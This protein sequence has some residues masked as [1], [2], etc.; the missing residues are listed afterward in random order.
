MSL[1]TTNYYILHPTFLLYKNYLDFK[2]VIEDT[3]KISH[4]MHSSMPHPVS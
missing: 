3:M 2:S 4:V 1:Q